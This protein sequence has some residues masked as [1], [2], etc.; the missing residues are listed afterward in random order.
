MEVPIGFMRQPL[1]MRVARQWAHD[2][3]ALVGTGLMFSCV[4]LLA[5]SPDI[6]ALI[7]GQGTVTDG[8]TATPSIP[9]DFASAVYYPTRAFVEG[10]SRMMP[11]YLPRFPTP[12]PASPYLPGTLLLHLPFGLMPPMCPPWCTRPSASA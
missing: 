9:K 5:L 3:G 4:L 2:W 7:R 12:A 11:R 10:V 6:S 8:I 1:I